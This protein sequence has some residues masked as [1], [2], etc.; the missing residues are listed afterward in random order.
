MTYDSLKEI[1]LS[2]SLE[3]QFLETAERYDLFAFDD[4]I[5]YSAIIYKPGAVVGP[6]VDTAQELTNQTDFENNFK[7]TA[8]KSLQQDHIEDLSEAQTANQFI[9]GG[10]LQGISDTVLMQAATLAGVSTLP[11][12]PNGISLA[13]RIIGADNT[14]TEVSGGGRLL[15]SSAS[16]GAPADTD[17]VDV[18]DDG[19]VAGATD[20]V[21]NIPNGAVLTISRFSGGCESSITGGKFELFKDNT[22]DGTS[23]TTIDKAFTNGSNFQFDLNELVTGN[24]I[25][26]IR[27]RRT[28]LSGGALDMFARW[29]GFES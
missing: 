11:T 27:M 19:D 3:W 13:V 17:P 10:S 18:V 9:S 14:P 15:I 25:N 6:S 29:E 16:P 20:F 21:H 12:T 26:L 7:D 22:G 23:L 1:I 4:T 24:G 28:N 8:N 2:K 5:R